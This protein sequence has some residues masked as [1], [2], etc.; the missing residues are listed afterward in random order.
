MT[1]K[2]F[3]RTLKKSLVGLSKE[4]KKKSLEYYGEMLD[5]RIEEGLSEEEAVKALGNVEEIAKQILA[6]NDLQPKEKSKGRSL[7]GW[8]IALL[9]IGSPLWLSLAVTVVAL[10]FAFYV[11]VWAFMVTMYAVNFFF[12]VI[13]VAAVPFAF[14]LLVSENGA[15]W[16]ATLGGGLVLVGASILLFFGCNALWKAGVW[17]TKKSLLSLRSTIVKKEKKA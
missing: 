4:D 14:Y 17:F 5:D 12:A 9:I 2:E 13:G 16:A 11:V 15:A 8:V 1:K 10:A 6:D 7:K 3:L